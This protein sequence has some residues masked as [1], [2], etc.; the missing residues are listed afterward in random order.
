M[1][2]PALTDGASS[3]A[4]W[5]RL[6][7]IASIMPPRPTGLVSMNRYWKMSLLASAR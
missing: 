3:S 5:S 2:L 4:V 6:P 1:D 7:D